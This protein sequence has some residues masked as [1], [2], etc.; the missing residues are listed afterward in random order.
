MDLVLVRN[1]ARNCQM[2][3]GRRARAGGTSHAG[4]E[5]T[6]KK[7]CYW[8]LVSAG[9]LK[10]SPLD[11]SCIPGGIQSLPEMGSYVV[12]GDYPNLYPH[13]SSHFLSVP[14]NS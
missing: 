10:H 9:S 3:Q 8:S 5:S 12:G 2:A 6:G 11:R 7:W 1:L 4:T 13:H 14:P